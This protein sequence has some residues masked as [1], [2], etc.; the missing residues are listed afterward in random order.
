MKTT[1]NDP[2]PFQG[3]APGE[4]F[5]GLSVPGVDLVALLASQKKNLEAIV[6]A[7][8]AVAEGLRAVARR[9]EELVRE[10]VTEI[11]TAARELKA[12][13]ELARF[14]AQVAQKTMDQAREIGE[15]VAKA[16]REVLDV[17][18]Q[19]TAASIAEFKAAAKA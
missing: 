8:R 19:R 17:V 1:S 11:Q 13:D 7:N 14:S 3:F 6:E 12:P 2:T 16:N 10:A 9:Q 15:L 4:L 5:E 18:N